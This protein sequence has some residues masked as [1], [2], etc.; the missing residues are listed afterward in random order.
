MYNQQ[1]GDLF[2]LAGDAYLSSV[3]AYATHSAATKHI[4]HV[5][6][7]HLGHL[8]KSFALSEPPNRLAVRSHNNIEVYIIILT[9]NL[10]IYK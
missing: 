4:F 8:A 5:K 1:D 10:F 7:L 3:R 6:N 2:R 9:E